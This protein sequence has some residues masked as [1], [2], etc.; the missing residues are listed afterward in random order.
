MRTSLVIAALLLV[1]CG[2]SATSNQPTATA[3]PSA[4]TASPSASPSLVTAV[5][6]AGTASPS[7]S[8]SLVTAA[9]ITEVASAV[10]PPSSSQSHPP[11]TDGYVECEFATGVDF[12]FSNCPVTTRF[13]ARL[14]Q[15]P[16]ASA[17]ARPFCRC[18]NILPKR[19]IT[20]ESTPS[21]G[22]AHVDLGNAHID[23]LMTLEGGRL[24]VDDTQCPGGGAA[25]SYY[26]DPVAP[27]G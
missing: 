20:T 24:L 16:S 27:C 9:A 13:L 21:G 19:D 8:P 12:E 2:G 18:Q 22:V 3:P 15:N 14:R 23:L 4:G 25:T 1:S 10:F 11:G 17:Q 6:S 7:P 26:L 5:P